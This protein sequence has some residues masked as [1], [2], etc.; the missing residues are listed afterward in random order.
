MQNTITD[1]AI[2]FQT[3]SHPW[4][5]SEYNCTRQNWNGSQMNHMTH[6]Q[7]C[8]VQWNFTKDHKAFHLLSYS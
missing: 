6:C 7:S 1:K 5:K 8:F 4:K 3:A 2:H